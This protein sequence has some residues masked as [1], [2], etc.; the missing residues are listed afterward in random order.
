MRVAVLADIHG[1]LPALEAV[2]R[3]V[4]AAGVDA[5]VLGGDLADG[6]MPA[7]TLDRLEELAERAIWFIT[8]NIQASAS[9]AEALAAFNETREHQAGQRRDLA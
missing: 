5:V 1:N 2:L 8:G 3:D 7:Q 9:D 6:P 4:E